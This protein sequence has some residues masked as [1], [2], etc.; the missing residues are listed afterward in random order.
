MSPTQEGPE[1]EAA[2][3]VSGRRA[4]GSGRAGAPARVVERYRAKPT[5]S[6]IVDPRGLKPA[7]RAV[8]G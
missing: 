3:A 6:P 5:L 7:A 4:A 8:M 2:R 1:R